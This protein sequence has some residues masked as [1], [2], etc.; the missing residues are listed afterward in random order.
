MAFTVALSQPTP[1]RAAPPS[2]DEVCRTLAQAAADN[3]LPEA[4]FTRLIWQESRFDP[5][6]VS[7]AGAQGIAQ[8]MPQT[9]ATRGLTDAFEPL[10]AL[11]ESA[12]YLRELRT[13][14]H[15][16][17]G[18]AAAAY[19]AGP[20][21]VEAWLAGRRPLPAETQAYVRIVTGYSAEAWTSKPPPQVEPSNTTGGARC[22][23]VA[24]LMIESTRHRP[25]LTGNPAWGP[26]G[27]QLAGNWSEGRV[28]ATYERLRRRY[29]AVLGDRLPLV[30]HARRPD[31]PTFAVRVS[32]KSRAEA[33]ALCAK[34]RAAGGACVVFRNPRN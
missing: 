19:N 32:E 14:F 3:R 26:W 33:D 13:T 6:A 25:D 4:F 28:L 24:R 10:Q 7:P 22:I 16:N 2:V 30:L 20:D 18:L 27:V 9:A 12:S 23:E 17:L 5:A 29:A 15:G 8:F 1:A 11:R 31:L 21:Q 34:L